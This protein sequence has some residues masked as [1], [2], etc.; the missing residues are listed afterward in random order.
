MV[1]DMGR[2]VEV[3]SQNNIGK[4]FMDVMADDIPEP[5]WYY[6]GMGVDR[7]EEIT[8]VFC[9]TNLY[10]RMTKE[11]ARFVLSI[12]EEYDVVIRVLGTDKVKDIIASAPGV[13]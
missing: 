6:E 1:R 4:P 13:F 3:R 2:G 11:D 7:E 8:P 10:Y 12:V 5:D 9:E